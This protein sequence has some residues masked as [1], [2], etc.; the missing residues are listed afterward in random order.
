MPIQRKLILFLKNPNK[1]PNFESI[2]AILVFFYE[3]FSFKPLIYYL[4]YLLLYYALL[5][6]R[7]VGLSP[8]ESS[9]LS[10]TFFISISSPLLWCCKFSFTLFLCSLSTALHSLEWTSF[11][12]Y[13]LWWADFETSV[14]DEQSIFAHPKHFS[15]FFMFSFI[16]VG[17][18]FWDALK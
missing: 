11:A 15:K 4:C 6:N 16:V 17:L 5:Y 10:L 13:Y 18:L 14:M 8:F 3:G 7:W 1:L 12:A 2:L 9:S